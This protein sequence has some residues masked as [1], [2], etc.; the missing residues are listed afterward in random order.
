[1]TTL[2]G[3]SIRLFA[4][5]DSSDNETK[6]KE[7]LNIESGY[8]LHRK[9]LGE[10][11]FG[12]V[13]LGTH[14]RT[15]QKV[16]IKMMNK[17]KLGRVR[18]EVEALK[19]L[20]HDNISKLLQVIE[21]DTEIY[22]VLEYCS[23]GEL[24]DYLISKKRL[25]ETE[26]RVI[27][28]DLFK[29]LLFIHNRGFAHR[30]LKPEN[31]LFDKNHKI[32]LIDFGLAANS[33]S[34]KASLS[35]LQTCCGSPA[36]A[37]PELLRGQ[38]Y[39][40]PAVDVW[41]AGVLLFSL[42]AGHLPFDD[43]N[44]NNLYKKIQIG[45]FIM[46]V[47]F[48]S[49][50]RDLLISMLK[51]NPS[52]R[53]SVS[54]ALNHPWVQ[55]VSTN[56]SPPLPSSEPS[57]AIDLKALSCCGLLF[58]RL[59]EENLKDEIKKFGYVTATYLLLKDNPEAVKEVY[60]SYNSRMRPLALQKQT[61]EK[62]I[63]QNLENVNV[64]C[65]IAAIKRKLQLDCDTENQSSPRTP[66]KKTKNLTTTVQSPNNV[67]EIPNSKQTPTIP[68]PLHP[69]LAERKQMLANQ[70]LC[71][72]Y[73]TPRTPNRMTAKV[74]RKIVSPKMK[75]SPINDENLGNKAHTTL[76]KSPMIQKPESIK[77]PLREVHNQVLSPTE[78]VFSTPKTPVSA[79]KSIDLKHSSKKS[80]I[81][82][83]MASATPAKTHSPRKLDSSAPSNNITMTTFQDPKECINRLTQT[84]QSKGVDCKQKEYVM[85]FKRRTFLVSKN[86]CKRMTFLIRNK[87]N[88]FV[89]TTN[90]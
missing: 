39:S 63:E 61:I 78:N 16:A 57:D 33:S 59:N 76:T 68:T 9:S 72:P 48:S 28:K 71:S 84:L 35:F 29:V 67:R 89:L 19:N 41:S 7:D 37:A 74:A 86:R 44:V 36:Y 10:G 3:K 65:R 66:V 23:G 40:G 73:T 13:R 82:R 79:K 15:N 47:W 45:R 18:I 14:L 32:K 17:E 5:N 6:M 62:S 55:K 88:R 90:C 80:L 58:P 27:M 87:K 42:L 60:A 83:L 20:Q 70:K 53:I 52:E 85:N 2:T 30:D 31:I 64:Q 12:K 1:M 22:L 50:V 49:D 81:R 46:P 56:I 21:T 43:D 75:S 11:G 54:K 4:Q 24:F 34:N 26:V 38:T 25:T 8:Y 51:T 69:I 77:S